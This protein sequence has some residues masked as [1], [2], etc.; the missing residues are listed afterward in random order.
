[1][2]QA[3]LP[4]DDPTDALVQEARRLAGS[5]KHTIW[6]EVEHALRESG[7]GDEDLRLLMERHPALR[8]E[9]ESLAQAAHGVGG[10]ASS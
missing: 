7:S 1:M 6:Q 9:I 8:E 3:D 2:T 10:P 5:G 4:G